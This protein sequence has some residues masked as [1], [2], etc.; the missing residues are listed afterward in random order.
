MADDTNTM[1]ALYAR[2]PG[3]AQ[4]QNAPDAQAAQAT[5]QNAAAQNATGT[6]YTATTGSLSDGAMADS[7]LN[8]MTAEDSP[9]MEQA[10]NTGMMTAARRGLQNSSI[11]AG[12]S[13]AE[14][15][16]AATPLALQNS[17][18]NA[19]N[20]MLDKGATNNASAFGAAATN[21]AS[22]QNAQAGTAVNLSNAQA[23]N[24]ASAQNASMKT[25]T[26]QFNTA[27]KQNV[28]NLNSAAENEMRT[29]V[30]NLNSQMN[31]QYLAGAQSMDLQTIQQQ[32][33]QLLAANQSASTLYQSFFNSIS[34]AMQGNIA[35]DRMAA[36][37]DVQQQM[38][39]HGLDLIDAI[40]QI[41]FTGGSTSLPKPVMGGN[42][43]VQQNIGSP[44]ETLQYTVGG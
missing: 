42:N 9:L 44:T 13:E 38:L 39:Q 26:D 33:G 16:K 1:D 41:N 17:Q 15:V 43:G 7:Q 4:T 3:A 12:A 2:N 27:N 23:A 10:R 34:S 30:L 19:Q 29:N 32:Y 24:S 18:V 35:P 5:T 8:K 37:I 25:A 14:A 31:K 36:M 40:N 22:S 20:E 11:A 21:A 6:G 28:N